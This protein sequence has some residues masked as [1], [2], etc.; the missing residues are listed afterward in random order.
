MKNN[1]FYT[2]ALLFLLT[3][4]TALVSNFSLAT[5]IT[6]VALLMLLAAAKFLLVAFRFMELHKAHGFW[7]AAMI[8]LVA[9]IVS[10]VLIAI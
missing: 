6:S 8:V 2:L 10:G 1:L 5:K 3:I 7:K 4:A 9:L